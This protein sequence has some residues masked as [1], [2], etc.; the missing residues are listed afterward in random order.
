MKSHTDS[1][2][3]P[4]PGQINSFSVLIARLTWVI[5]G[6]IALLLTTWGIVASGTGWFTGLDAFF[7]VVAGLMLFGRWVEHRSGAATTLQGE[8][9]TDAE[10]RWYMTVLPP[11]V[12]CLWIVANI[13]GNHVLL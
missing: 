3:A 7:G 9:A 13:L 4:T 5:L 1:S 2:G 10:F 8:P 12:A 11:L 6:P